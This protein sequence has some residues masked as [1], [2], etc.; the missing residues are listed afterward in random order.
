ARSAGS[1]RRL[2][3]RTQRPLPQRRSVPRRRR[4]H[5]HAA[6][7]DHARARRSDHRRHGLLLVLR[8]RERGARRQGPRRAQRQR[9]LLGFLWRLVGRRLLHHRDGHRDRGTTRL[10]KPAWHAG[11]RRGHERVLRLRPRRGRSSYARDVIR[12]LSFAV[13]L[14]A[15]VLRSDAAEASVAWV[16]SGPGGAIVQAIAADPTDDGVVYV[17]TRD[18]GVFKSPGVATTWQV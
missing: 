2:R 6:R 15:I 14:L 8:R 5:A 16:N 11:Q 13:A 10:S 7:A 9:T 4:L 17:G 12:R 18:G 3:S 1:C